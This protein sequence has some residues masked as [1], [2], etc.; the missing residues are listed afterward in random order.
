MFKKKEKSH[1]I[2]EKKVEKKKKEVKPGIRSMSDLIPIRMYDKDI[3]AFILSKGRYMDILRVI[4]KDIQNLGED[5]IKMEFIN[6][7]KIFRTVGIDIKFI[8]MNFPLNTQSQRDTLLYHKEKAKDE[9][10]KKW[11]DREI[12]ELLRTDSGILTREFYIEYFANS[13]DEFLKRRETIEKYT[14]SGSRKIAEKIS[15]KEKLAILEKKANM[16]TVVDLHSSLDFEPR[17]IER[18]KEKF[19]ANL[20]YKIEA[21]GGVTFKDSSYVRFGDGYMRCLHVYELPTR[22]NDFWLVKLFNIP[23]CICTMDL[24][25]KNINEVKKNINKS[26]TEEAARGAVAKN[27]N[28]AYDS[29]KRKEEL[30]QLFDEVSSLGEV[31]K[32]VDFRIFVTAKSLEKLEVKTA[33]I[34][35]ELDGDGYKTTVMLNEQKNEWLSLYRPFSETHQEF[36]TMPPLILTSEQMAIGFPF[37]YSQLVDEQGALLGFTKAGGAVIYNSYLKT[38]VRKHYNSIVC[39]T[40]GSGKS[41]LLKKMFKQH[42]A[43]G[44]FL[45]VF[46]VSG[47]F[48][49]LTLEFGGRIIK[50]GSKGKLNPFE[51][52]KSGEDDY[53][54]YSKHISKLQLFFATILPSMDDE[55]SQELA[56]QLKQFYEIYGLVP[57]EDREITGRNP[58]DYPTLSNFRIYVEKAIEIVKEMDKGALTNVETNLNVKKAMQLDNIHKAIENLAFNYGRIFDGHTTIGNIEKEKIV[59]FDISDIKDLGTVFVAEMQVLLGLCWDNAISNGEEL[60]E[61]WD[62]EEVK[63]EDVTEFMILIDESHRWINTSMLNILDMVIT[64]EREA[65]KYFIG[66]ILA[67][68]SIRDFIPATTTEGLEKIRILFELSQYKFLFKQDSSALE[69]IKRIFGN[70]IPLSQIEKIPTLEEGENIL[71]ISGGQSLLFKVWLSEAYEKQIFAGGK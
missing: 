10:R 19:D 4:P 61:L 41:T 30:Q 34:V 15:R 11:L 59:T 53:I 22:V 31:L 26:I 28:E 12:D 33:E 32:D 7:I 42:A 40:M 63:N 9:V 36:F 49:K 17:I 18:K 38:K 39:G 21:K 58:E 8:S 14:L 37:N 62:A 20:F 57:E 2:K 67:S 5:D 64:H 27:Y 24:H 66:I 45:R 56:V 6:L 25:T 3:E 1:S 44:G 35:E 54:S 23:G 60:K 47:E 29:N 43:K 48:T 71:S 68:Q 50:F 46:D 13:K 51:I 52:L 55:L 70:N 16:N 65:R 69:H